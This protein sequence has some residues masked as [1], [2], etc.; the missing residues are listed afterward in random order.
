MSAKR[1]YSLRIPSD[2]IGRIEAVLR[3]EGLEKREVQNTL[4]SYRGDGV[5]VNMYPS[6]MLLV[7]GKS[8]E[9]WSEKILRNVEV[10]EGP[11]AGCD[12]AGKGETFGPLVLC[13]AVIPPENFRKVLSLGPKDS[14][15]MKEGEIF[16]KAKELRKLVRV[17]CITLMPER[18]NELYREYKNMNRLMDSAYRKLVKT[19][20][21]EFSP[22][23]VVVDAYS[24]RNPFQDL[25]GVEFVEKGES[26]VAVS[27]ASIMARAKFLEKLRDL[28]REYGVELPRGAGSEVKEAVNRLRSIKPELVEKVSKVFPEG[29]E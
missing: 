29:R 21:E 15:S 18:F 13:C 19:V 10:P 2:Q 23:R 7:Q 28:E 25:K 9:R 16:R 27:V 14:K 4:W 26:D 22:I 3:E 1:N 8:A 11:L 12:E 20:L 5:Y 6:G 24:K 17:R